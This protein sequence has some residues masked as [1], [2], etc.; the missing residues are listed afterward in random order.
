MGINEKENILY[1]MADNKRDFTTVD[2]IAASKA[3]PE[4][5][6]QEATQLQNELSQQMEQ[7]ELDRQ[8]LLAQQQERGGRS[9]G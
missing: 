3:N 7:K 4:E 1:V 8:L 9:F 2:A 5:R 6:L